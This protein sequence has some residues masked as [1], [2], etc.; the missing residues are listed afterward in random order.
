MK[1]FFGKKIHGEIDQFFCD[2]CTP[3]K[4]FTNITHMKISATSCI[5]TKTNTK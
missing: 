2:G 3:K 4:I 5:L 1:R